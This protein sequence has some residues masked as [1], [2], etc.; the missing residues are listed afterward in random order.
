MPSIGGI[1]SWRYG[2]GSSKKYWS[3][4][5]ENYLGRDRV[6][7]RPKE[8]QEAPLKKPSES[9]RLDGV[10]ERAEQIS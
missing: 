3:S 4:L 10:R 2:H 5:D 8:F 1:P 9:Q 7:D 6:V